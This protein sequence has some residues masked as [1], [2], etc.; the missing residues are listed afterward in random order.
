MNDIVQRHVTK[1][2]IT[3]APSTDPEDLKSHFS[4][5][6]SPL[7]LQG[8]KTITNSSYDRATRIPKSHKPNMLGNF[9]FSPSG[10]WIQTTTYSHLN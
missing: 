4:S 6:L 9:F 8:T 7:A 10:C 3:F 5:H 2:Q 1:W